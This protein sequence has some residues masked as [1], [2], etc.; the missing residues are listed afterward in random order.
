MGHAN[1]GHRSDVGGGAYSYAPA[2][3]ATAMQTLAAPVDD[4]LF[5]AGEATHP[6]NCGTV[7]AA[8]E[9]GFRAARE[10]LETLDK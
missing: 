5:F 3:S 10:V 7:D 6:E 9:T 8:L 1:A 2:G 4:T